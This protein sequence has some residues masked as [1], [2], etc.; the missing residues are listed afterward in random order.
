M[1][2]PCYKKKSASEIDSFSDVEYLYRES[3][4]LHAVNIQGGALDDAVFGS[5]I[6]FSTIEFERY[7]RVEL[8]SR[9]SMS[10][11]LDDHSRRN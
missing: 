11:L 5:G 6:L 7:F 10:I 3:I 2:Q 9:E 1:S 8:K 4:V